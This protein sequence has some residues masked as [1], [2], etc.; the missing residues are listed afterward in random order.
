MC[1]D[2]FLTNKP[3]SFQ[4]TTTFDTGISDFHKMVISLL[5]NARL[6]RGTQ[7]RLFIGIIKIVIMVF[8]EMSLVKQFII[9]GTGLTM[10]TRF[11][12]Y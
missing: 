9:Q 1:I 3:R 8:S 4:N 5:L 7:K 12:V 6:K 2:L 10:N 11:W